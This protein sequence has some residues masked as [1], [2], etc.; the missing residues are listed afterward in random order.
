MRVLPDT[1]C[2]K[3]TAMADGSVLLPLPGEYVVNMHVHD[4]KIEAVLMTPAQFGVDCSVRHRRALVRLCW[5]KCGQNH[6]LSHSR[7]INFGLLGCVELRRP[8]GPETSQDISWSNV[9][10]N[11]Y[12]M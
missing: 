4:N 9:K 5:N 7:G 1:V 2:V 11:P 3:K 6:E 12:A 8:L 10:L